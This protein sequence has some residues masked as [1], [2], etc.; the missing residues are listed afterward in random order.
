M[1]CKNKLLC[2]SKTFSLLGVV[3][4]N[5]NNMTEEIYKDMK[6]RGVYDFSGDGR[7]DSPGHNA[8]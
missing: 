7:C 2:Y 4:K 3:N 5:Y 8:K 6:E 1:A